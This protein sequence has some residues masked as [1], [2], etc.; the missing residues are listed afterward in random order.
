MNGSFCSPSPRTVDAPP[1]SQRSPVGRALRGEDVK[2]PQQE[3]SANYISSC[4]DDNTVALIY[5]YSYR[6]AVIRNI[7]IPKGRL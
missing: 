4:T 6:I 7:I 3:S 2:L 5:F 1:N